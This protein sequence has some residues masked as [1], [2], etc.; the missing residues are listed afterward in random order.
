MEEYFEY[1]IVPFFVHL[2]L[3]GYLVVPLGKRKSAVEW[4]SKTRSVLLI[5]MIMICLQNRAVGC[6]YHLTAFCEC[7]WW[8]AEQ[9]FLCEI[10]THRP[11]EVCYCICVCPCTSRTSQA[12]A[13]GCTA[14]PVLTFTTC[15]A[16]VNL[17][18]QSFQG[19]EPLWGVC[20]G[21]SSDFVWLPPVC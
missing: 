5:V 9:T 14:T 11:K 20:L 17:F 3:S 1:R 13:H 16:A 8:R 18:A 10:H 2:L 21:D 4:K 12:T 15:L 6:K 19:A 7:W